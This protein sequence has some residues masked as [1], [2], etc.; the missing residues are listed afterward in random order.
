MALKIALNY[1]PN[2]NPKKRSSKQIKFIIFHYTGMKSES[3][4]LRRL[5]DLQSEYRSIMRVGDESI[6]ANGALR[7]DDVAIRR[8][9]RGRRESPRCH[10]PERARP[11]P[12]EVITNDSSL[13]PCVERRDTPRLPL[14]SDGLQCLG[15][16]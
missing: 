9:L 8:D 2:F 1:S 5:T 6:G 15:L 7:G 14:A 10:L 11:P 13:R 16:E 3:D 4:A 12:A